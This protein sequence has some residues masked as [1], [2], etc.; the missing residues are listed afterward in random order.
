[1]HLKYSACGKVKTKANDDSLDETNCI[2]PC[3]GVQ[4][5]PCKYK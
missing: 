4:Y 2:F 5:V 1:M 3:L